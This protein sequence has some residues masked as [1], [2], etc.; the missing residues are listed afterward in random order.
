M[1]RDQVTSAAAK[2]EALLRAVPCGAKVGAD[3]CGE[4]VLCNTCQGRM[5]R[6]RG[7]LKREAASAGA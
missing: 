7:I 6:A 1:S 5:I 4:G 2:A 3:R